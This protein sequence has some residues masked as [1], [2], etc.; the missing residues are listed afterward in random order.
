MA[1]QNAGLGE[2]PVEVVQPGEIMPGSKRTW[3]NAF[4]RRFNDPRLVLY[5]RRGRQQMMH[6]FPRTPEASSLKPEARS[7]KPEA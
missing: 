6:A 7:L 2:V 4:D 3:A 1:A 5:D